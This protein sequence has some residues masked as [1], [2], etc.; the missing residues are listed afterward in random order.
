[1]KQTFETNGNNIDQWIAV[2]FPG[3]LDT[4]TPVIMVENNHKTIVGMYFGVMSGPTIIAQ[5][6]PYTINWI[7]E[8]ADWTQ[9][10]TCDATDN[11]NKPRNNENIFTSCSCGMSNEDNV[12][13]RKRSIG[14]RRHTAP[15]E[16]FN[17]WSPQNNRI[18]N[19]NSVTNDNRYPWQVLVFNKKDKDADIYNNN[20]NNRD[21][22]ICSGSIISS[23]HILTSA[24]CLLKNKNNK[25]DYSLFDYI[26]VKVGHPDRRDGMYKKIK[27]FFF[28]ELAF[29][30]GYNYNI[31]R[32]ILS[33]KQLLLLMARNI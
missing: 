20:P 8:H 2:D 28:H 13:R 26:E 5:L 19:G 29:T 24:E 1:M 22:D 21:Y 6:T 30:E 9:E 10:S 17:K 23:S 3:T 7:M 27:Q 14:S 18:H 15:L 31:G 11:H 32:T 4:G 12:P 16:Y 25:Q 33:S